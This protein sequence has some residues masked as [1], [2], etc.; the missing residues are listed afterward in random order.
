MNSNKIVISEGASILTKFLIN[1]ANKEFEEA[2]EELAQAAEDGD[3]RENEPYQLAKEKIKNISSRKSDILDLQNIDQVAEEYI[4]D[5]NSEEIKENTWY[6]ILICTNNYEFNLTEPLIL[7]SFCT[8]YED[9]KT[10]P[11]DI[12]QDMI[13]AASNYRFLLEFNI[14]FG[15]KSNLYSDYGYMPNNS[16]L[17]KELLGNKKNKVLYLTSPTYVTDTTDN[18]NSLL[19]TQFNNYNSDYFPTKLVANT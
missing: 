5:F 10:Y 4:S 18:F 19:K 6:R 11:P 15:T 3:L 12:P 7:N 17:A 9:K 14:C 2:S 16:L 1:K 13:N 8:I